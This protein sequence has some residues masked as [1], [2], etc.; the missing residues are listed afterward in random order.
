MAGEAF[1]QP[2]Q[3]ADRPS[4]RR[5]AADTAF[6]GAPV[7]AYLDDRRLFL[8]A[9]INYYT[10]LEPEHGWVARIEGQVVGYLL[11]AVD[12]ARQRRQ[13]AHSILPGMAGRALMGK[14]HLG[15]ATWRYGLRLLR[16]V[17]LD[18]LPH[19]DMQPYPAHLHINLDEAARGKGLGRK[20]ME[21]YLSQ[22]RSLGIPGVHLTTTDH[23]QAA[24]CLYERLG[25]R[26]LDSRSTHLWDGL[27]AERIENRAY[28]LIL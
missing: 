13:A 16:A 10:D 25:F 5:I 7:E 1:I 12:T 2:Y 23:N 26:L 11:G 6:F 9:F 17:N 18:E 4:V 20:L 3:L 8:D 15:L 22:L 24:C 28:G 21:A 27:V 19:V 14:Y